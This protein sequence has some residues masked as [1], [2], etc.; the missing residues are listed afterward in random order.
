M[1]YGI[2]DQL[3]GASI[4]RFSCL[5]PDA[6]SPYGSVEKRK[7]EYVRI[8]ITMIEN[9]ATPSTMPV[10]VCDCGDFEAYCCTDDITAWQ[11]TNG[12]DEVS[13]PE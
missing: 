6:G 13:P 5:C 12:L 10:P 8:Y 1:W 11:A 4:S 9:G 7:N 2:L 3:A